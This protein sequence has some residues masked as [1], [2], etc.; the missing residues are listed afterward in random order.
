MDASASSSPVALGSVAKLSAT[1]V[2]PVAGVTVK[3]YVDPGNG[4]VQIYPVQTVNGQAEV[5]VPNLVVGLYKVIAIAGSDCAKSTEAYMPVFDPNG[6]FVTG[7]GWIM[8]PAGAYSNNPL[9][10]GKANFG[11]NAKY[12]KG[13]NQVDGNTEF[14]FKAGDLNFKSTL[15]ESGSLVISGKKAT[16]RGD[17]TINGVPGYKF[18]LVAIDG[19][20]NGGTAPDQF[21]IKIWG[22]N[23]VIYDNG[24]AADENSD[25]STVLGGGSIVIQEVKKKGTAKI[26]GGEKM[27]STGTFQ[28]EN[29]TEPTTFNV[30][31][32]PNP[33]VSVFTIAVE[34]TSTENI[35]VVVYDSAGKLLKVIVK[36]AGELIQFGED[37][38]RGT[39]IAKI[40]QGTESKTVNLM[41]N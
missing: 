2:P 24:L 8:S 7:G 40:A 41:K 1:I 23:G 36:K 9:L 11:F 32:Y 22:A 39:Y 6:S 20:Y 29:S 3:F 26:V 18:T 21:R 38:P 37:L 15:H 4:N 30:I 14:Q 5:L 27:I 25:V 17:G 31:A 19:D 28:E 34:G 35:Q 33:S 12:K 13:N 16:Y 10:T